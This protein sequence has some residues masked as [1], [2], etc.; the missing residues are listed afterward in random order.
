L[1]N[2]IGRIKRDLAARPAPAQPS[3]SAAPAS[4]PASSSAGSP[5]LPDLEPGQIIEK[6]LQ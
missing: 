6:P 5:D 3:P 1:E 2:D 4:P